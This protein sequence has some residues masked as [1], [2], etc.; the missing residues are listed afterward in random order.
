MHKVIGF[1]VIIFGLYVL[2]NINQY[3]YGLKYSNGF[4]ESHHDKTKKQLQEIEKNVIRI[5]KFSNDIMKRSVITEVILNDEIID[6]R[7]FFIELRKLGESYTEIASRLKTNFISTKSFT[8]N[9]LI[10]FTRKVGESIS[11]FNGR[12]KTSMDYVKSELD[13]LKQKWEILYTK[14]EESKSKTIE[15]AITAHK[16]ANIY[17][18]KKKEL[19]STNTYHSILLKYIVPSLLIFGPTNYIVG[20]S[21]ST[22]FTI[23]GNIG[24]AIYDIINTFS[25]APAKKESINLIQEHYYDTGRELDIYKTTITNHLAYIENILLA[26][27]RIN[28]KSLYFS[29]DKIRDEFVTSFLNALEVLNSY[30]EGNYFQKVFQQIEGKNNKN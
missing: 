7:E 20:S 1:S 27:E 13:D 16:T 3:Y 8:D 10:Q 19:E 5:E 22:L 23:T 4:T 26:I 11:L 28:T 17:S 15:L 29:Y 25:W 6:H 30:N 14:F 9:T 21:I 24:I 2:L 18:I 12:I